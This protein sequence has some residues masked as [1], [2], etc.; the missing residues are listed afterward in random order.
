MSSDSWAMGDGR[1]AMGDGRWAMGDGRWA[2]QIVCKSLTMSISCFSSSLWPFLPI[3]QALTHKK[4][5]QILCW[6]KVQE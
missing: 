3:S 2:T 6:A 5:Q 4:A 1:W